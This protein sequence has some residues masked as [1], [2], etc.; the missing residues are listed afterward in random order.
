MFRPV[1]LIIALL[2]AALPLKSAETPLLSHDPVEG[3]TTIR[4]KPFSTAKR[5]YN[6]YRYT[7]PITR[8]NLYFTEHVALKLPPGTAAITFK[9]GGEKEYYYAV[10]TCGLEGETNTLFTRPE[11][12]GPLRERNWSWPPE[13]DDANDL[14]VRLLPSAAP[15]VPPLLQNLPAGRITCE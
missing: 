11:D 6:V 4:W 15:F 8:H 12:Y 7:E 14:S 10:S 1:T 13:P 5:V 3:T 9:I 2:T